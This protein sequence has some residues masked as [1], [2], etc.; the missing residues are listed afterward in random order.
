MAR[1]FVRDGLYPAGWLL[2]QLCPI[3]NVDVCSKPGLLNFSKKLELRGAL[4]LEKGSGPWAAGKSSR[5]GG[6][7][8]TFQLKGQETWPGSWLPNKGTAC[9]RGLPGRRSHSWF[10]PFA[11]INC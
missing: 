9:E 1:V 3:C 11:M 4:S 2:S 10:F 8:P 5:A 6:A 7:S